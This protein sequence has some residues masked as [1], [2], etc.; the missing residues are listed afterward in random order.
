MIGGCF[1]REP[2]ED[3]YANRSVSLRA[4]ARL[5]AGVEMDW[6]FLRSAGDTAYDGDYQNRSDTLQQVFGASLRLAPRADWS[7]SLNAGRS[8]DESENFKDQAFSSRFETRRDTLS[9]QNDLR[10]GRDR[11]VSLGIDY[12]DD[13]VGGST[14]Y[15]VT[16]RDDLGVFAQYIGRHAGHEW[17]ASLRHDENSQFDGHVTGALAWGYDFGGGPRLTLSY[18]TAF[19]APTFDELYFPYY[20]N[21]NLTPETAQS[22]EASLSGAMEWGNWSL[23]LFQTDVDAMITFDAASYAPA[24]IDA[25]RIRGLEAALLADFGP[26]RTRA[27]LALLDP[28]NRGGGANHGKVLPRRAGQSL[29]LELDRSIGRFAFGASV[30]A[31]GRRYDDV[32]NSRELDAYLTLDL[33]AEYRLDAVWRLQAR[34]DNLFDADYETAAYYNQPGRSFFVTLRYE[35]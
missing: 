31:V 19:K 29:N 34:L 2:D 13:R 15:A 3:G 35:P 21:P 6:R 20:G 9:L 30:N 10:F 4:G 23:D 12:H 7:L 22:V 11:R 26:W 5:G 25:A 14:A 8:R 27:G 28:I 17:Q 1:T 33:R 32:A 24:N 16:R 18:G